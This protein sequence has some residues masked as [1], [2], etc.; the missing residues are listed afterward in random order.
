MRDEGGKVGTAHQD[1]KSKESGHV[2]KGI[3][4]R[5]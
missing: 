4:A 2:K 5:N 3:R 1:P